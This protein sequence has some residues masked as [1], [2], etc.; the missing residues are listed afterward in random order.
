MTA[1]QVP[2]YPEYEGLRELAQE[3]ARRDGRFVDPVKVC[4][5]RAIRRGND[6][7]S[8]VIGWGVREDIVEMHMLLLADGQ[9]LTPPLPPA[10]AELRAV[11]QEHAARRKA[12]EAAATRARCE[13]WAS[14]WRALPVYVGVAYNYSGPHHYEGHQSGADHIILVT[15][16]VRLG[17]TVRSRGGAMCSTPSSRRHQD[18]AARADHPSARIATCKACLRFAARLAGVPVPPVLLAG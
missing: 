13:A 4:R 2:T 11:Q 15:E 7:V 18:F 17:R 12:V 5:R 10:L 16:D 6:W 3:S 8:S 9:D 1:G 14:V